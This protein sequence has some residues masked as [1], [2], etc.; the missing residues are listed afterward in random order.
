MHPHHLRTLIL[1]ELNALVRELEAYP[2][3]ESVWALPEGISNSAGT[4]ALHMAGNLH[5]FFGAILGG[6]DYTRDREGEFG[7]RDVPRP[8]LIRRIQAAAAAVDRVLAGMDPE[9][10]ERPFP[11]ELTPGRPHTGL[12]LTHLATHLSY[13]LGQVDYHR[14]LTTGDSTSVDALS[15]RAIGEEQRPPGGER[16]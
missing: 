4:L 16:G 6:E 2:S 11:V 13:H 5:H 8:E 9:V 10:L 1:R 3:E 12:F 7:D 15:L 14:R